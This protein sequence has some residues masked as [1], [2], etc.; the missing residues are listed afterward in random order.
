MGYAKSTTS[1]KFVKENFAVRLRVARKK[2]G[3][4][5]TKAGTTWG[6]DWRTIEA[7]EQA[8]HIPTGLY[9]EKIEEILKKIEDS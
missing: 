4:S 8:R 2:L 6:I 7:W 1:G 5:R 3:L 9:R